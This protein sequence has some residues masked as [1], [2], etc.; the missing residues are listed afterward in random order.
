[1]KRAYTVGLEVNS[2]MRPKAGGAGTK[3]EIVS[4]IEGL[5]RLFETSE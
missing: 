4:D 5:V 1:M 2:D 3:G